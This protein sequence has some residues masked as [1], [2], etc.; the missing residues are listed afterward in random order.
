[1]QND[2]K[3]RGPPPQPPP[4]NQKTFPSVFILLQYNKK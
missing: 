3:A 2:V 1:M 4:F